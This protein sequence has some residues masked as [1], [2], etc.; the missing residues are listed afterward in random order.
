MSPAKKIEDG[1]AKIINERQHFQEVQ[2]PDLKTMQAT[3]ANEI[4]DWN[5]IRATK[6]TETVTALSVPKRVQN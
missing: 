1:K 2:L 6:D 4:R 3:V 5:T